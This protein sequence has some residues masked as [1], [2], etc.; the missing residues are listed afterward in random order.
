MFLQREFSIASVTAQK[1]V[2]AAFLH[3]YQRA[4]HLIDKGLMQ[5]K[6]TFIPTRARLT[7]QK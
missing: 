4:V 2:D 3:D 1:G 6:P 5:V 7:V